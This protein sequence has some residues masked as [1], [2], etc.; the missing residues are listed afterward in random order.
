MSESELPVIV[1]G[2]GGHAQVLIET[3]HLLG[4]RVLSITDSARDRMGQ[5]VS[6]IMIEGSDDLVLEHDPQHI[7]LANAIG[8]IAVPEIRRRIYVKFA[9]RGYQFA[10]IVH[11]AATISSSAKLAK[12]AQV[13]AGATI[14]PRVIVGA[15]TIIN[16]SASVDHDCTIG[17]HTH[18][19]PG[20]ILSGNVA[21]GQM[22][23]IGTAASVI[24]SVE[25]G[26]SSFVAAG[27]VVTKNLPRGAKVRGVPAK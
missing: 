24:Q 19:A 8:S 12:G 20:V 9:S 4:R 5:S 22:C 7:E 23:H 13:M 11:P 27:S 2:A 15:N 17:M 10:T 14:Q 26:A 3:L 18:I 21:V 25:L 16:T 1:I 6:G